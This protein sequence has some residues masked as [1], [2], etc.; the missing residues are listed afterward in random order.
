MHSELQHITN[1]CLNGKNMM[2]WA[3]F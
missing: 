1:K 3:R 2:Q